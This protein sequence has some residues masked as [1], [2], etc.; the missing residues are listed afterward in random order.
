MSENFWDDLTKPIFT[1]AP[2]EDVTDTVFREIVIGNSNPGCLNVLFTEFT[3]TD[4]LCH[5]IGRP[6]VAQRLFVNQSERELLKKN[7]IRLVAQIWGS[8]PE[9]YRKAIRIIQSEMDF[10]GID[11][12]MGCPVKNI[13]KQGSCSALIAK[14]ELAKEIIL[15]CKDVS[16]KPISVKTRTGIKSHDT[17]SWIGNLLA[18]SPAAIILHARTQKMMT[19]FPAEWSE[20]SKA[21]ELRNQMQSETKILGNGDIFSY[22]EAIEKI[23]ES[24]ADGVMIGRGIFMDPWFFNP[25]NMNPSPKE[26]IEKLLQ[27]TRLYVSTWGKTK[28]FAVLKRF[29]KIYCSNFSNASEIRAQLME[30]NSMD[31]V[32]KIIDHYKSNLI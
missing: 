13:V 15:A 25:I 31:E 21:V 22:D 6:K 9:N 32:E 20:I 3:S 26:R 27:H 24:T 17:E 14:P 1:L 12:N 19:D 28:K 11:I 10:D 23:S 18:T 30:T 7:N 16:N 2:M 8:N 4:G 5:E 29:F